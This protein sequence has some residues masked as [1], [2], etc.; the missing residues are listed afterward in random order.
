M[1]E[2]QAIPLSLRRQCELLG[3][4]RSMLYYEPAGESQL[5]LELMQM[6]DWVH[7]LVPVWGSPRM[8][9]CLNRMGY[10]VNHK[11]VERLMRLMGIEAVY[12]KPRTSQPAEGHKVYPYLLKGLDITYPNQVWCADITYIPVENGFFYLVAVM[13]WFS[14][15]VLSWELSNSLETQFC[16]AALETALAKSQPEI[17][18]TDQGSQFT[19]DLFT[20]RLLQAEIAISMDGRGRFMD[21]IFIERLW[22]SL[23]YEEVYLYRYT[24]GKEAWK[25]I[26]RWLNAYNTFRPHQNLGGKTPEEVYYNRSKQAFT[27][28][29]LEQCFA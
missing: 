2:R 4:N 10:Q 23:K 27:L 26:Q 18:N 1:V 28:K 7:L 29:E 22:R 15:Y 25:G 16:L 5:N 19:S 11:R 6:I 8:T 14:R 20:G 12:R 17:F 21:N 3:I 24:N 9:E 13:D